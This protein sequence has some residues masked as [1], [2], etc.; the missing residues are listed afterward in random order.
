VFGC[1]FEDQIGGITAHGILGGPMASKIDPH[2][3]PAGCLKLLDPA[4]PS[5]Q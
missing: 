5:P 2:H 1:L 4:A 3:G